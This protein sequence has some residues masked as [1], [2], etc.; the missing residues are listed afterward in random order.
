MLKQDKQ[1]PFAMLAGQ[2]L[3]MWRDSTFLWQ[4]CMH[5]LWLFEVPMLASTDLPAWCQALCQHAGL[6]TALQQL[7]AQRV[8]AAE[9]EFRAVHVAKE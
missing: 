8:P 2:R 1:D 9:H 6:V 5:M 3:V 4:L 7:E